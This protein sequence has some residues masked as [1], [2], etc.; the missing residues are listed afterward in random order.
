[1]TRLLSKNMQKEKYI[2][3][4][5]R[6]EKAKGTFILIQAFRRITR[7]CQN[8]QL[9][10]AGEDMDMVIGDRTQ[11]YK[12]YLQSYIRR[13]HFE[14]KVT[15][16]G[17]KTRDELSAFYNKCL[18]VIVPSSKRENSPYVVLEA[19]S[20]N[21]TVIASNNGGL[22][23]MIQDKMNGVLYSPNTPEILA[24][25][26]L[27]LIEHEEVRQRFEKYIAAHK[28]EFDIKTIALQTLSFYQTV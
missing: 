12:R 11:S 18:F 9:V 14:N 10:I 2:L 21:K 24:E 6:I 23:E 7:H 26:M 17:K 4:V 20:H 22:P 8:V 3:Y 13:Y 28:K 16:I 27:Y 1:M 25:K 19:F 15:F 5:G